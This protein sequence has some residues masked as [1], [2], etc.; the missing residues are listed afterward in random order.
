MLGNGVKSVPMVRSQS[1]NEIGLMTPAP[2]NSCSPRGRRVKSTQE[3]KELLGTCLGNIDALV[4]GMK[5]A[6][7]WGLV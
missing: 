2:T 4:E 7:A 3:K 6:G 5:K 1:V